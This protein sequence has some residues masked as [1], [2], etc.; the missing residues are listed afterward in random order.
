MKSIRRIAFAFCMFALTAAT[1]ALAANTGVGTLT[2]PPPFASSPILAWSWGAS[3]SGTSHTGGGGGSGMA[4]I[5]DVSLTRFTD[6]Q[7]PLFFQA[8]ATGATI[9]SVVL[10]TGPVTMTL[11]NVLVTSF[12]TGG[13][14]E[15]SMT[16]NIT[17]NFA[18]VT[19]SV[20]GVSAGFDYQQ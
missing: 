18:K 4:N 5:Q 12:S 1:G 7:S 19:Y 8:V 11:E 2:L 13:S 17:L 10:T 9:A 15:K 16:E 20:G 14:G 6:A 3:N